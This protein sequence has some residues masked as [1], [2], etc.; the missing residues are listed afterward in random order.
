MAKEN[1]FRFSSASVAP[2]KSIKAGFDLQ[3]G[4]WEAK[5]DVQQFKDQAKLERDRQAYF[6]KSKSSYRK[7]ATIPDIIAIKINQDHGIDL[8][9]TTFMNDRDRIKKLRY[10]LTTEYPDLMINS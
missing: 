2:S 4:E 9:S 5:A 10:I 7:M 1:E 6:G 3:T 8:H